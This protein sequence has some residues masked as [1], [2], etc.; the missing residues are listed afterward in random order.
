MGWISVYAS[1][2]SRVYVHE[3]DGDDE[4]VSVTLQVQPLDQAVS[5]LVIV[6]RACLHCELFILYATRN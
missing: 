2:A 6:E 3:E 5:R 1:S 4:V